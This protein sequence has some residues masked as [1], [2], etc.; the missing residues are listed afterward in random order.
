MWYEEPWRKHDAAIDWL[1]QHA[2]RESVV[3]TTTPQWIYLRT[4]LRSVM[5]PFE[6]DP[7]RADELMASVPGRYLIIDN[8]PFLDVSRRYAAPVVAR[9]PERW[10]LIFPGDSAGTSIY[11]S[12]APQ[13]AAP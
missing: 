4:G 5:P 9:F 10:R 12:T 3:I 1:A 11:E 2:P 8:L 13:A 6:I 7:V